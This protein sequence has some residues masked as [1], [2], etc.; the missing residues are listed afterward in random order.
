MCM[1]H[2][3][4]LKFLSASYENCRGNDTEVT[5]E[6][7]V[8]EKEITV[9]SLQDDQKVESDKT[10]KVEIAGVAG[11]NVE[12]DAKENTFTIINDDGRWLES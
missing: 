11:S 9:C 3:I 10:F 2:R 12:E 7:G 8:A 6:K 4:Q 1:F 5:F